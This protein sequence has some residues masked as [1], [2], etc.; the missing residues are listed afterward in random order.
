MRACAED[1]VITFGLFSADPLTRTIT[2]EWATPPSTNP[3]YAS[4]SVTV[5]QTQPSP[6]TTLV[7][8]L[9][10]SAATTSFNFTLGAQR[11]RRGGVARPAALARAAS[12]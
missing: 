6:A 3:P 2:Q 9:S 7:G 11:S 4:Y 10:L 5:Q 1:A 12:R 8:P